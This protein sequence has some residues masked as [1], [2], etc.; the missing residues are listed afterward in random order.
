M[1][2][3][4]FRGSGTVWTDTGVGIGTMATTSLMCSY[5][6]IS[7]REERRSL[8]LTCGIHNN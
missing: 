5:K 3:R 4:L 2:R 7:E 6:G 1:S 8:G